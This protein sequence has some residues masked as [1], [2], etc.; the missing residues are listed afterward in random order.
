MARLPLERRKRW[1]ARVSHAGRFAY[2]A[3]RAAV[4]ILIAGSDHERRASFTLLSIAVKELSPQQTVAGFLPSERVPYVPEITTDHSEFTAIGR[5]Q[6]LKIVVAL[7]RFIRAADGRDKNTTLEKLNPWQSL[8]KF[9]I[10]VGAPRARIELPTESILEL[11]TGA[12][13]ATATFV[14]VPTEEGALP[15]TVDFPAE[16]QP[17]RT[18]HA[19]IRR[20]VTPATGPPGF[21]GPQG[22]AL[23]SPRGVAAS[24]PAPVPRNL[25]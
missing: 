21:H 24:G 9:S 19:R 14:V 17:V 25:Y 1:E 6:S 3:A 2:P 5:G 10:R 11:A 12:D 15:V 16:G 23:G 4:P 18:P 8:L 7:S 13:G 20:E 22:S